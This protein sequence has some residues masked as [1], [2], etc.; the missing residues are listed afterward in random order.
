LEYNNLF[1]T[2]GKF[3]DQNQT[4]PN[5]IEIDFSDVTFVSPP[6]V[7]F[8][9][10]FSH[11]FKQAG[12]SVTFSNMQQNREATKY[13]DDS[14]FFLTHLGK[15]LNVDGKCR[16]TTMELKQIEKTHSHGWLEYDFLP[17]IM[18]SSGLSKAS[19]AEVK[20]CIQELFNNISDHTPF[21]VGCFFGQWY[22]KEKRIVISISDFGAGIPQ[23]VKKIVP[24]LDDDR[25]IIKAV[26]DGFSSKS[27]PTNRGAGLYLLLLNIVQRFQ[28]RVTIRSCHGY[29]KF[30]NRRDMIYAQCEAD[31]GF[32]IGT[33]IDLVIF[34]D[35]IP[36]A[37][38]EEAFE[39]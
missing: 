28:G 20:T 13:L 8:L 14:G 2:L 5:E 22:P 16:A 26:E 31:V 25:A 39:W 1:K 11:W 18:A 9:S 15:R 23:N 30:E 7:A 29:V 37:E 34:T 10:N 33:T 4:L 32:C 12:S 19:L 38:E 36:Y 24:D 21:E 35:K 27:V 17:W 6:N 3:L